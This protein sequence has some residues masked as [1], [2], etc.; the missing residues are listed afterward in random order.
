[1]RRISSFLW[2]ISLKT[3]EKSPKNPDQILSY[4]PKITHF[5]PLNS[6][7]SEDEIENKLTRGLHN[8][9]IIVRM[10]SFGKFV[11][12]YILSTA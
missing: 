9:R 12:N 8:L 2:E 10:S 7:R 4:K 6:S 5:Y 3:A 11:E 1:M